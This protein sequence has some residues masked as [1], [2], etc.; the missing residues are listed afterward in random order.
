MCIRCRNNF[1]LTDEGL[2]EAEIDKCVIKT[3]GSNVCELCEDNYHPSVS[4]GG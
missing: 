3:H 4:N 1:T 2:C